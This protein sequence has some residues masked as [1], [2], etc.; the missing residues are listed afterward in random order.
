MNNALIPNVSKV[1]FVSCWNFF[2]CMVRQ[3]SAK[4]SLVEL[5]NSSYVSGVSFCIFVALYLCI[6]VSLYLCMFECLL[7]EPMRL[8]VL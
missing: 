3:K 7:Q 5:L 4:S 2:R 6:S 8:K 1:Y